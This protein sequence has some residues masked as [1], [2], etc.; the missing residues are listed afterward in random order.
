[1]AL[2]RVTIAPGGHVDTPSGDWRVVLVLVERGTLTV[3]EVLPVVVTRATQEQESMP[4]GAEFT[5]QVGD[6]YLSPSGSGGELRND[7]TD[8][9]SVLAGILYPMPAGTPEAVGTPAP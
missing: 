8:E 2:Q 7:G 6:S 1:M 4:A 9:V 5:L 3:R